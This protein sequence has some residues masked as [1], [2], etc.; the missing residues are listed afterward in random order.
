MIAAAQRIVP[1]RVGPAIFCR[2]HAADHSAA[3]HPDHQRERHSEAR[4]IVCL[5]DL[6]RSLSPQLASIGAG[7]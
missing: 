4:H 1:E 2:I 5:N 6:R 7:V 3:R